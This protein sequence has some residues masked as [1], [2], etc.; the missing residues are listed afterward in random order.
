MRSWSTVGENGPGASS[1]CQE[2]P[3]AVR[4]AQSKR[5]EIRVRP[6]YGTAIN[7]LRI[8]RLTPEEFSADIVKRL[9]PQGWLGG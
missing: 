5:A 1:G 4:Q 3:G 6:G 2:G 7:L 8:E 9:S